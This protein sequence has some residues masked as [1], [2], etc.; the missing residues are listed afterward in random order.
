LTVPATASEGYFEGL[1]EYQLRFL[2]HHPCPQLFAIISWGCAATA[3]I[4]AVIGRHPDIYC[5]H[6][7]NETWRC[8]GGFERLDGLR[9]L[10]VIGSQ[11][12]SKVA[13]GDVHGVSRHHIPE[14]RRVFGDHFNAVVVIRDPMPRFHSNLA[15]LGQNDGYQGWDLDY[16]DPVI[17][18]A[19]VRLPSEDYACRFVVHAANMLNAIAEEIEVGKVYRSEDL[20]R[21]AGV[22]GD[23]LDEITRGKV[24]PG[25]DWLSG[26]IATPQMNG[27][28]DRGRR[29]E[30]EDWE[31]DVLRRVVSPKAWDLYQR[32]GYSA[33][34]FL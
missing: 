33:P 2:Q 12:Y 6:A 24:R 19:G 7:A 22:L 32:F 5:A 9:Y 21:D 13:A 27:H 29:T 28:G 17:E 3:W 16:L 18:R 31:M 20:T 15:L 10:R 26:A 8:L 25:A 23:L 30:L 11:A 34:D 4:A 14:L 1:S